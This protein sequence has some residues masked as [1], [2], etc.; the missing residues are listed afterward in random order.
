[1]LELLPVEVDIA[2]VKDGGD[3]P[4][5]DILLLQREPQ[6]LNKDPGCCELQ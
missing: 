2:Q 5:D 3:D 4:E 6:H 1:M